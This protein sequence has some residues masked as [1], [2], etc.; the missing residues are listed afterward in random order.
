MVW[1]QYFGGLQA[2]EFVG[3]LGRGDDFGLEF[4]ALQGGPGEADRLLGLAVPSHGG[5]AVGFFV[6]QQGGIGE[7]AGGNDAHHFA[8]HGAF[9]GAHFAHLLANG[10]AAAELDQ[11]GQV[12]LGRMVRHAGH[13]DG[14]AVDLAAGGERDIEQAGGFFGVGEEELVEVAHAVE[15]EFVGVLGFDVEI[16]LHHGGYG[17][18][19]AHKRLPEK[20]KG[21]R[22]YCSRCGGGR[23][24]CACK[25]I[26]PTAWAGG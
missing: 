11:F 23:N 24:V 4:A 7:R 20:W 10:H 5:D 8:R 19:A 25:M 16:L 13:F 14:L 2:G 22:R 9:I 6:F 1:Q 18:F 17:A 26:C 3:Q 21:E 12:L 15:Q